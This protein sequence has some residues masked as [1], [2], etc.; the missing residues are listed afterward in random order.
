MDVTHVRKL[1]GA[2]GAG[3]DGMQW[4]KQGGTVGFSEQNHD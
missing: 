4:A 2:H 1:P 3:F